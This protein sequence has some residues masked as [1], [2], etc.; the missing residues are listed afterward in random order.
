MAVAATLKT[1]WP[2]PMAPA[3]SCAQVAERLGVATVV[4][5]RMLAGLKADGLVECQTDPKHDGQ[6]D[7]TRK[8]DTTDKGDAV[9]AS[10]PSR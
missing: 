1:L 10:H 9:V 4:A 3:L 2:S 8:W 7:A 5:G 6:H